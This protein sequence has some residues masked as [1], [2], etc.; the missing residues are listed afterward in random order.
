MREVRTGR[1]L[2]RLLFLFAVVAAVCAGCG[3]TAKY[4]TMD[5]EESR[6][7]RMAADPAEMTVISMGET[8]AAGETEAGNEETEGLETEA[9]TI[10]YET[11]DETVVVTADVLNVR[12]SESQS[13]R[14]YVQLKN[15]DR[16][17]RIGYSEQWSQ[18][19]YDGKTAYVASDMVEVET[20]EAV[21]AEAVDETG[22]AEE[23]GSAE[24]SAAA[25]EEPGNAVAAGAEGTAVGAERS[26]AGTSEEIPW[27]G[28]TVAI[29]AG[30][31]AKANAEKEPIGPSS[32]TLK[33]KMPAGSVGIVSGVQEYELTLT[34]AKKL[35][36]ELKERGYHV[37]MIRTGHD[38]NLSNAERSIIANQSEADILIRLH[39]NSMDNSSVYGA[40]SMCMT[41]QNPYNAE[42]HDKSYALS[43]KIIDSICAQT[44]TRN[45]GVQEVDNSGEINWCEI[46]VSVVEMGF[47]SNPDEDRWLQDE[48]Y[49][50][51][52]VAGIAAA[53]DSYFAETV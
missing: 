20:V 52:I 11:V 43:K 10:R 45:R 5:L 36:T 33:A 47:L 14:I 26:V 29:D 9:E 46:P 40:L 48:S 28:Y 53:V 38:V 31:Q 30:H 37:V 18:V 8:K 35:E 4:Q 49:Q 15:G 32:E 41:A 6:A 50:G 17:Q 25:G 51:K 3:G 42:L 1:K 39:A 21:A 23:D 13:A 44:G 7:A 19:I 12:A 16:L 27:N 24:A 2:L 34:V 22:A